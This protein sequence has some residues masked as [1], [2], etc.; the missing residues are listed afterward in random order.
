MK[1]EFCYVIITN[2]SKPIATTERRSIS[3]SVMEYIKETFSHL[4]RNDS[5]FFRG[6]E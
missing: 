4:Q 6:E 3:I 1:V 2:I 5:A